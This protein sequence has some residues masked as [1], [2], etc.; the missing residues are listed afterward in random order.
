MKKLSNILTNSE[1]LIKVLNSNEGLR[2]EVKNSLENRELSIIGNKLEYIR[3][4]LKNYNVN[5]MLGV[6]LDIDINKYDDF[7]EGC[8]Y[9]QNDYE[10][11]ENNQKENFYTKLINLTMEKIN[12]FN[13]LGINDDDYKNLDKIM[14]HVNINVNIIKNRLIECFENELNI[15]DVDIEYYFINSYINK[16][17]IDNYIIDDNYILYKKVN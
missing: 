7:I 11:F 2:E 4:S 6:S 16:M 1:E 9:L 17:D 13:N 5:Y 3:D 10:I 12:Y 14:Y 8:K 15:R